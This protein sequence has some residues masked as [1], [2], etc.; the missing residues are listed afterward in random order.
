[1][2]TPLLAI[3]ICHSECPSLHAGQQFDTIADFDATVEAARRA[4]CSGCQKL[5]FVLTW[6]D[7]ATFHGR[8]ELDPR[9]P[10][11][12]IPHV[13]SACREVLRDPA[14]EDLI[15]GAWLTVARLFDAAMA[16]RLTK[17]TKDG[18]TCVSQT[19]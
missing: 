14:H 3:R 11:G 2:R 8:L 16:E 6:K 18:R 10:E 7:G 13:T 17:V 19:L 9:H 15:P 4:V 12:L 5:A 1:M